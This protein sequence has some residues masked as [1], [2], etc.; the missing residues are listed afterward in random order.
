M[1]ASTFAAYRDASKLASRENRTSAEE[2]EMTRLLEDI[3]QT[4]TLLSVCPS[5]LSLPFLALLLS[6]QC[7]FYRDSCRASCCEENGILNPLL[8]FSM[9]QW[10]GSFFVLQPGPLASFP[11]TILSLR[12]LELLFSSGFY[13]DVVATPFSTTA[14]PSTQIGKGSSNNAISFP[15]YE[16]FLDFGGSV[17]A[18]VRCLTSTYGEVR[19]V[20]IDLYVLLLISIVPVCP[21]SK[22]ESEKS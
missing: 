3:T 7:P 2:A 17:T 4:Q 16:N 5:F 12:L 14:V 8:F 21:E 11:R 10:L 1:K 19:L 15:F 9:M 13:S 18:L 20:G 22:K 6:I